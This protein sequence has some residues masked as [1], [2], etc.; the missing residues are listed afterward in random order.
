MTG[1][2][3]VLSERSREG[4][5][6]F[7]DG[8]ADVDGDVCCLAME[9]VDED[10]PSC[11]LLSGHG[12][13]FGKANVVADEGSSVTEGSRGTDSTKLASRVRRSISLVS[14][15]PWHTIKKGESPRPNSR[16]VPPGV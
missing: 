7:S 10:G 15:W 2:C 11:E 13:V 8:A 1:L 14:L 16:P 6:D 9:D 5:V 12:S 4:R 3:G